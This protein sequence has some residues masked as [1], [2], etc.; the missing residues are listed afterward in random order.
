M[1]DVVSVSLGYSVFDPGE[2]DHTYADMDGNTTT[3]TRASDFAASLGVA[4]VVAAGNEGNNAWHFIT[5]P[6]DA[7]SVITVGAANSSG[8]R[9]SF[10]SFGPT[11]D[12]RTKPDVAALGSGV[13]VASPGGGA[14]FGGG[15]S[16][17]APMVA[18]VV[19]QI[20]GARPSLTPVE[21]RDAL[22][23]TASQSAAPDNELAWGIIDAVDAL[24]SATAAEMP[25]PD[26]SAWQ[27]APTVT[28]AGRTVTLTVGTTAAE[29]LMVDVVDP[30]GRRVAMWTVA[31]CR[32]QATVH[33]L[34]TG[35][36]FVRVP[37]APALRLT[38][39]R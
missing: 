35:T 17:A 29:A 9:S 21:V 16:Y 13:Y 15:T 38:V 12:G 3:V 18:G 20:L 19:A 8:S 6:A 28:R 1:H 37:N 39:V 5:A 14:G 33:D 25:V 31:E 2:G 22:R 36:Y 24:A 34:P 26:A 23:R 30:L 4:V 10:S 27:I 7:D 32:T 11:A